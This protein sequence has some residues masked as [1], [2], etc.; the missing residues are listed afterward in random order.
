MLLRCCAKHT[1]V[2]TYMQT[3]A[4]T[5]IHTH[6]RARTHSH[7]HTHTHTHTHG[8]TVPF[9][10]R[11]WRGSGE[12]P[13]LLDNVFDIMCCLDYIATRPEVDMDRVGITGVCLDN[14]FQSD[15][16]C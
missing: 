10:C 6:M 5:H 3:R 8:C 9:C 7:T 11:A 4:H 1:Y 12:H 16:L 13:F 15:N 14:V 2:H